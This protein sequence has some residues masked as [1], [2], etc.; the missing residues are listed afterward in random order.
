[1]KAG[2]DISPVVYEGSGVASY[3]REL[4]S[5]LL[6]T[7]G[8]DYVLFGASLRRQRELVDFI[9]SIPKTSCSV[10]LVSLPPLVLELLWNRWHV[11]PIERFTGG[12]DVFH[13]SDWTE[14]PA[15]V[16]KVTTIHDLVVY[17]YPEYLPRKII[18]NHKRRLHWVVKE[19]QAIIADSASTKEDI[20]SFLKIPENKI[21]VVHLGVTDAFFPQ[22]IDA[23]IQMR[24]KYNLAK[25][26]ILCVGKRE[27]RKNLQ[28]VIEAFKKLALSDTELVIVGNP[29]WGVD[30]AP[31]K[32][33]KVLNFV[34]QADLT[35]LYTG[36]AVFVYPSLYEGFGLPV[37]EAMAC[38]CP[39]VTSNRG[40]LREIAYGAATIVEP[41]AVEEI[42]AGI[43]A[44][45]S[46]T[47]TKRKSVVQKGITHARKFTWKKTAAETRAVYSAVV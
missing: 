3:T 33:T 25:N 42:A 10:K 44:V 37:L 46:L 27:P 35:A 39:V 14:P 23:V 17:K 2:I 30:V 21:H 5:A 31:V 28:R 32:N 47:A 26:Y 8:A 43:D 19:S 16:P 45:L 6:Q 40:S 18:D 12:I 24:K 11:I 22:K 36:A 7:G 1:M 41:E 38:G 9:N 34:P 13:T 15:Q 29:G 20:I 4:T